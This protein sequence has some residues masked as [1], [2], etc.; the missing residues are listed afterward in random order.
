MYTEVQKQQI[1]VH[2]GDYSRQC[3]Q[4]LR[5]NTLV[6][7]RFFSDMHAERFIFVFSHDKMSGWHAIDPSHIT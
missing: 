1:P 3:G 7:K 5:S 6:Y 4:G 2:T